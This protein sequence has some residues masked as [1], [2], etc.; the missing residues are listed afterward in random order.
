MMVLATTHSRA[1]R[2]SKAGDFTL[3]C[4]TVIVT[5]EL[6]VK[7]ETMAEE[8]SSEK[9]TSTWFRNFRSLLDDTLKINIATQTDT[10]ALPG[11]NTEKMVVE[12]QTT[13]SGAADPLTPLTEMLK[14]QHELVFS[15]MAEMGKMKVSMQNFESQLNQFA[16][17]S[18]NVTKP[19][20]ALSRITYDE[21][22]AQFHCLVIGKANKWYWQ[23]LEDHVDDLTFGYVAL[24]KELLK[25]YGRSESDY[26]IIRDIMERK[27]QPFESFDEYYGDIHDLRFRMKNKMPE[28]ELKPAL[29]SLVFAIKVDNIADLRAECKRAEKFLRENRQKY[30]Q[31]NEIECWRKNGDLNEQKFIETFE[32][33]NTGKKGKQKQKLIVPKQNGKRGSTIQDPNFVPASEDLD[34]VNIDNDTAAYKLLHNSRYLYKK[35]NPAIIRFPKFWPDVSTADYFR[36][37]STLYIPWKNENDDIL[38]ADNREQC[39]E[40][41]RTEETRNKFE[42][43]REDEHYKFLDDIQ[44][45]REDIEDA[46]DD[47]ISTQLLG[48]LE[49][50]EVD[51]DFNILDT[52]ARGNRINM[53]FGASKVGSCF[54]YGI[55]PDGILRLLSSVKLQYSNHHML[56]LERRFSK[57][58]KEGYDLHRIP[59]DPEERSETLLEESIAIEQEFTTPTAIERGPGNTRKTSLEV[60]ELNHGTWNWADLD[61]IVDE[62]EEVAILESIAF[63]IFGER[64][65]NRPSNSKRA[66]LQAKNYSIEDKTT[67]DDRN[68]RQGDRFDTI[69]SRIK[70]EHIDDN[71]PFM[72]RFNNMVD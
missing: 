9:L 32:L 27:Q 69:L 14:Q 37:L 1:Q 30:R 26:D 29:A 25:E 43:F 45:N 48:V 42:K 54:Q 22:F 2:K 3:T 35:R 24:K 49:I 58:L 66:H 52:E 47:V 33:R 13:K 17:V 31:V 15:C 34:E 28:F 19:L 46:N 5:L 6:P 62:V 44:Q 21:L 59:F 4:Q 8:S 39:R 60:R 38:G 51:P 71:G 50:L 67:G 63:H 55:I 56:G 70:L 57:Q 12:K 20:K 41:V 18:I 10:E 36:S 11:D 61:N 72:C 7:F 65:K 40:N 68:C 53:S 23:L 16:R 64:R